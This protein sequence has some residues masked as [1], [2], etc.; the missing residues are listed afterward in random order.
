MNPMKTTISALGAAVLAS[1]G[2]FG[3]TAPPP[4]AFEV[5]SVKPAASTAGRIMVDA[6]RIS[7]TSVNLKSVLMRAYDVKRYQIAGPSWLGSEGYDIIAK[8]PDGVP[9][10]QIPA[11]LQA[12]LAERFQMTVHRE[13]REQ[14]VYALVV[15][16]NGPKLKKSD[17]S[18]AP[19]SAFGGPG[20]GPPPPPPPPAQST[21][22]GRG[23]TSPTTLSGGSL[24]K[25]MMGVDLNA[26]GAMHLHARGVTLSLLAS[27][28]SDLMDRPVVDMTGIQGEYDISLDT[29]ADEMVGIKITLARG[30]GPMGGASADGVPAPESAPT[31]SI[32]T[33]IQR[34]GLKLEPRKGPVEYLVVDKAEKVP[35]EN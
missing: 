18:A 5:A 33:S 20:G 9:E 19:I 3:Q 30:P 16:K 25:G 35:T 34:Y 10:E 6:G 11:M 1:Y 15:G 7:C 14:P 4:P 21:G 13:T 28:L 8:V 32:F 31:A 24:P 27:T 2:L 29:A 26:N 23:A 12:L 17:E 22:R